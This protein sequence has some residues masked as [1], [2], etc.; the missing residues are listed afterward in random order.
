MGQVTRE[1][2][3]QIGA[4][5]RQHRLRLDGRVHGP[6]KDRR[7]VRYLTQTDLAELAG[8]SEALVAQIESGRYENLNERVLARLARALQM[9]PSQETYLRN[10]LAVSP[11][12]NQPAMAALSPAACSVVDA[13]M[14][15]P[16]F[17]A[18]CCFYLLYWNPAL[19]AMLGDFSTQPVANRNVIWSMFRDPAM[20]RYWVDWEGNARNLVAALRMQRSIFPHRLADFDALVDRLTAVDEQF[21]VWWESTDPD[22]NPVRDKEYLHPDVGPLRLFQTATSVLGAPELAIV[23]MTPRDVETRA[24]LAALTERIVT[25]FDRQAPLVTGTDRERPAAD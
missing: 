9:Q 20:R 7:H 21:A 24:K 4:F 13:A 25:S 23:H 10:L 5:L 8:V 15:V 12:T 11:R 1:Q 14:P 16:S 6:A 3:N 2:R 18:D 22:L 17:V 19:A